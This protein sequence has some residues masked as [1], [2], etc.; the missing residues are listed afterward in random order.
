[1]G[2]TTSA[3]IGDTQGGSKSQYVDGCKYGLHNNYEDIQI[4]KKIGSGSY[5]IVYRAKFQNEK[6]AMKEL[7]LPERPH[8]RE[9]VLETFSRE[10]KILAVVHHPKILT[11]LGAVQEDPHYCF[12][13]ELCPGSVR[14]LLSLISNNHATVTWKVVVDLATDTAEA[15]LYL[16]SL[17]PPIV[18]RDLKAENLLIT[19]DFKCKLSDFGLSRTFDPS[20][21][22]VCGTPSWVAPEIFRGEHYSENVDT[23][24]YGIVLWELFC[25]QK[26]HQ[27]QDA[28]QLPYLVGSRG[29][30]PPLPRHVPS[31]LLDLMT[32]CWDDD[33]K[34]RP[35][36]VEILRK[37][38]DA[39]NHIESLNEVVKP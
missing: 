15:M 6:I 37:L 21:M 14:D 16:H 11:F 8:D 36:F 2:C 17:T 12:L 32:M 7:L 24:S 5:G 34:V 23:Y 20:T 26:P 19:D 31:Y 10:I 13:S 30:R 39:P 1:M 29:L 9:L 22:T 27:D 38:K 35:D 18:H 25:F 33:C 28:M 4:D 3:T